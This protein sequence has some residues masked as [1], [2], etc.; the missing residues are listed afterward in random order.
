MKLFGGLKHFRANDYQDRHWRQFP[1]G[2]SRNLPGGDSMQHAYWYTFPK[3]LSILSSNTSP[4]KEKGKKGKKYRGYEDSSLYTL[5]I[6]TPIM[7]LR[8]MVRKDGMGGG[9]MDIIQINYD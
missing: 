6:K 7:T 5:R 4:Q 3:G 9:R 2:Y 8:Q 1:A